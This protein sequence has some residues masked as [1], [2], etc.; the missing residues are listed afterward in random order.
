[1]LFVVMQDPPSYIKTPVFAIYEFIGRYQAFFKGSR[2]HYSFECG[3]WLVG[4][5]Y[6]P[7][8]QI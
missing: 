7:V 4:V 2:G 6:S 8:S 1:M 5:R 3:P